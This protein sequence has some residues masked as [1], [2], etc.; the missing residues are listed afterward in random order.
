MARRGGGQSSG[1][2]RQ[3]GG[4]GLGPGGTCKCPNCGHEAE[5]PRGTP[6]YEMVCPKCGSKMVRP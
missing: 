1:R 4:K 3:P 5:H 6:C 2:G